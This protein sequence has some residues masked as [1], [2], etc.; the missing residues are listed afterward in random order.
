MSNKN[1]FSDFDSFFDEF[2][3]FFNQPF[4]PMRIVGDV[5]NEEG[6]DE[7]GKW[8][9]QTFS[10]KDGSV[11]MVTFSRKFGTDTNTKNKGIDKLKIELEEC[12]EKQEYE[13][14]AE[15]RDQIKLIEQNKEKILSLKKELEQS[16]KEQNFEKAIEL[17]D[18]LKGLE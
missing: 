13:R 11:Q 1:F 6:E 18:Q 2:D 8:S 12:V 10:S 14:A 7:N 16:V 3:K 5:K 4:K 9:K 17:R 15:L